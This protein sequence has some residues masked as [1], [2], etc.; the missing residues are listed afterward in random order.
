MRGAVQYEGNEA[1][2]VN[3]FPLPR[4]ACGT[5]DGKQGDIPQDGIATDRREQGGQGGTKVDGRFDIG[6]VLK[7]FLNVFNSES[8][9]RPYPGR[10]GVGGKTVPLESEI[11]PRV[12]VIAGLR[13]ERPIGAERRQG[14]NPF[15][16]A[17]SFQVSRAIRVSTRCEWGKTSHGTPCLCLPKTV[18]LDANSRRCAGEVRR[19][20]GRSW[21][22]CNHLGVGPPTPM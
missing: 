21:G 10:Q 17:G 5:A 6:E 11:E 4:P 2:S 8:A 9:P 14:D 1:D 16:G 15:Q 19:I 20:C 7:D 13:E 18:T 12:A 3:Q 22:R